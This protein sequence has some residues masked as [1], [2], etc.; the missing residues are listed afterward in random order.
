[1]NIT[2]PDAASTCDALA[3]GEV[4]T[5]HAVGEHD[6]TDITC[7]WEGEER[8]KDQMRIEEARA[9]GRSGSHWGTDSTKPRHLF[10]SSHETPLKSRDTTHRRYL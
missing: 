3:V 6:L 2:H 8:K 10:F 5:L 9:A 7:G 1:M 4:H